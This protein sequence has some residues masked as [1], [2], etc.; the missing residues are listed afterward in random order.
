MTSWGAGFG[1][2]LHLV[3]V[4]IRHGFAFFLASKLP[5]KK[6]PG[7]WLAE[8]VT[9]SGPQRLRAFFEDLGGTFIKFGQMLALQ[10]D[11]ISAEYCTALY[12]LLD[13]VE[14]FPYAEARRILVA[15][16][17]G[18]PEEVFE[19]FDQEPFASASVGQVHV[20]YLR[21]NGEKV[22][23]KVQR[24][25]VELDFSNDIRLMR[26]A[27][28]T[29]RWL[30]IRAF[31][32]L[33]DPMSEFVEWTQEE[34]DYRNEARYAVAL[35]RQAAHNPKQ[36]VPRVYEAYTTRRTLVMEFLEGCTLLDFLRAR[37]RGDQALIDRLESFGFDCERFGANVIENFL[38]DVFTYG[39]YHAD[40]HPANLMILRDNV[41]GYVDFGII[42][43]MSPY[44]RRHLVS[45]TLALA[46]GDMETLGREYVKVSE[47]GPGS[48]VAGFKRDLHR[49][50][51]PWYEGSGTPR[52]LQEKFTVVMADMLSL[53]RRTKVMPERDIIKYI[54]SSIAIDGLVSRLE[55][56]FNVGRHLAETCSQLIIKHAMM[57]QFSAAQLLDWASAGGLLTRDGATRAAQVL[58]Q[59]ATG[60]LPIEPTVSEEEER[61]GVLRLRALQL[62]G[63]TLAVSILVATMQEPLRLGF[64]LITAE[65]AFL[66]TSGVLLARALQRLAS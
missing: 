50:A 25:S 11:T 66:A 33:I 6:L 9:L 7:G 18:E 39:I 8:L 56:S 60:T 52:W 5:G 62:A 64:N 29:I 20:A 37:D 26:A 38:G 14:P 57:N 22:A 24:P 19:R 61:E 55:P 3:R 40:L 34:L 16:L 42:G 1:R 41:V 36:H 12:K 46:R 21:E 47:Y 49:I 17:G 43:V 35:S 53:S 31:D 32:W 51:P 54:R 30:R 45:M 23:V 65:L 58:D 28:N 15:S 48:D 2:L 13:R 10:P 27:I 63:A 59:L 4:L 44:S